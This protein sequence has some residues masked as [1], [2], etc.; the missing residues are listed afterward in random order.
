MFTLEQ[1][2]AAHAR[3]KTGADFPR[4]IQEIKQLGLL[5][6]EFRVADG[7]FVYYGANGHRADR[8]GSYGPLTIGRPASAA[9]LREAITRHQ[10]GLSDFPTFCRQAAEAGVEKWVI[11]TQRMVCSYY[12]SDGAAMVEE[13][14][15]VGEYA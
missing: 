2:K 11:D 1:I 13:A 6:Y 7:S 8:E 10:Q 4:Y 3:V 14:I 5:H 12:S 15:P 9:A